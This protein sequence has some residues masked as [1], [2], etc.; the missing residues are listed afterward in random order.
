MTSRC[1]ALV[2]GSLLS[3]LAFLPGANADDSVEAARLRAAGE[4][5]DVERI[6]EEKQ[7]FRHKVEQ[8]NARLEYLR[9]EGRFDIAEQEDAK[10]RELL[11]TQDPQLLRLNDL[12]RRALRAR[13]DA[14]HEDADLFE[15]E[16]NRLLRVVTKRYPPPPSED[17]FGEAENSG[18]GEGDLREE[19]ARLA[20]QV[21]ALAK[22][23]ERLLDQGKP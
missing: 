11:R 21:E 7:R 14:Q 1:S 15:R 5:A 2:C 10:L 16:A 9:L 19:V 22:I 6:D 17:P 13:L 4:R 3:L 20:R 18:E 23:V 12:K 8:L